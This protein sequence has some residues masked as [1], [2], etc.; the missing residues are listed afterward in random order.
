[1]KKY[2]VLATFFATVLV[3]A[4]LAST[5]VD[6]QNAPATDDIVLRDVNPAD[7]AAE[8]ITLNAAPGFVV[9]ADT[10][11]IEKE[12]VERFGSSVKETAV[13]RVQMTNTAP[14][15][16]RNLVVVSLDTTGQV[17]DIQP[18]AGSPYT[19]QAAVVY[20]LVFFD[21]D[22]GAFVSAASASK[23]ILASGDPPVPPSHP[24]APAAPPLLPTPV[25]LTPD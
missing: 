12:A 14:A 3:V 10:G 16:D 19:G 15:T 25:T 8:G 11:A 21:P 17:R 24:P 5:V 2:L 9:K 7:L 6:T 4:V 22:T 23:P 20:T 13:A 1:M 18:P